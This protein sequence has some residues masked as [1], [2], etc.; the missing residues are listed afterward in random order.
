ML[1][2]LR[3]ASAALVPDVVRFHFVVPL[4]ADGSALPLSLDTWPQVRIWCALVGSMWAAR[5][6]TVDAVIVA[7][8]YDC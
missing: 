6:A 7:V 2:L 3:S 5:S 8:A 4:A 1:H